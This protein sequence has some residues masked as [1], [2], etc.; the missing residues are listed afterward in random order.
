MIEILPPDYVTPTTRYVREHF[1]GL[2]SAAESLLI[3]SLCQMQRA[4]YWD[5]RRVKLNI[6]SALDALGPVSTL[7]EAQHGK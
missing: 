6:A 3:E 7:F 1:R 4:A 2:N 5:G